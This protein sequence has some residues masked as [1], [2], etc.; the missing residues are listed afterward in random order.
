[1][2]DL[3]KQ[4]AELSLDAAKGTKITSKGPVSN[5]AG[6]GGKTNFDSVVANM[7]QA[8]VNPASQRG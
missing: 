3:P 2:A 7:F 5:T 8:D 4:T 1:M 6:K